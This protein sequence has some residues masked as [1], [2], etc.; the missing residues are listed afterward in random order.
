MCGPDHVNIPQWYGECFF[1]R[2]VEL[3]STFDVMTISVIPFDRPKIV[4]GFSVI[5]SSIGW[6]LAELPRRSPLSSSPLAGWSRIKVD[7]WIPRSPPDNS[8]VPSATGNVKFSQFFG[9]IIPFALRLRAWISDASKFP[10]HTMHIQ[11]TFQATP[12]Y[13]TDGVLTGLSQ[14]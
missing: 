9:V 5:I 1:L 8:T 2:H 14:K 13:K 4:A 3:N 11:G 12:P 7:F 6:H 10:P